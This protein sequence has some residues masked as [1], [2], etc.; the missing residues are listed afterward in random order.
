MENQSK[1]FANELIEKDMKHRKSYIIFKNF[2][3][4]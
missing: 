2:V 4:N 3:K 1:K